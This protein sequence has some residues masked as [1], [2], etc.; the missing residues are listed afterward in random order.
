MERLFLK[1]VLLLLLLLFFH[2]KDGERVD[3]PKQS[4]ELIPCH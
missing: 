3:K 1:T 2:A 4:A